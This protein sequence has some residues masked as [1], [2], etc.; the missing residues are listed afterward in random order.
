MI[1]TSCVEGEEE[2]W[3]SQDGSGKFVAHYVMPAVA[4][5][6]I[7]DPDD[8]ETALKMI[9]DLED[10]IS[11]TNLDF[12]R[13]GSKVTFHLEATFQDARELLVI[14]SRNE[15]LFVRETG[16][17]PEKIAGI[18]GSIQFELKGLTPTFSR[19]ISPSEIFPP[20]MSRRPKML[21]PST[22]KYIIHLPA[23]VLETNAHEITSDRK[24]VSW[25]FRLSEHFETPMMMSFTTK[26]PIPWWGW[27]ILSLLAFVLAWL[28]WRFIIRRFV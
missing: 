7:G 6:Q 24:T 4:L 21:G 1:F 9:D 13:N 5:T 12:T 26:L 16:C 3:I 17:D 10:G 15:E 28:V 23:E 11:I 2:I 19:T 27:A 20:M 14:T 22:F 8:F 18:A 25:S